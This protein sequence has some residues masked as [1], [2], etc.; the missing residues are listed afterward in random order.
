MIHKIGL[1][2]QPLSLRV[3]AAVFP[4]RKS[5]LMLQYNG[6]AISEEKSYRNGHEKTGRCHLFALAL[7]AACSSE[8]SKPAE[9]EKPKAPEPLTAGSPF[10]RHT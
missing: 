7:M 1:G 6:D 5:M 3:P 8:P 4:N 2:K 9:T 10:K